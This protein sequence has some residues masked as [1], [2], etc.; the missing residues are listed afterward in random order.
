MQFRNPRS[1]MPA[2]VTLLVAGCGGG[3]GGGEGGS[4]EGGAPEAQGLAARNTAEGRWTGQTSSGFR[5]DAVILE[6]GQT[7]GLY[8]DG[9]S[10][11][12]AVQGSTATAGG[13]LSATLTEYSLLD[14]TAADA[15]FNGTVQEKSTID[16]TASTGTRLLL[17]YD[18]NYERAASNAELAGTYAIGA[19][20]QVTVDSSGQFTWAASA[21]CT[22]GGRLSPRPSGRNVFDASLTYSGAACPH[23]NGTSIS[24]VA[25]LDTASAPARLV[26]LALRPDRVIGFFAIGVRQ[27][28]PV[29]QGAG[30][31]APT[32][33]PAPVPLPAAPP[34]LTPPAPA[35]PAPPPAPPPQDPD[36]DDDDDDEDEDDDNNVQRVLGELERR[37]ESLLSGAVVGG[38]GN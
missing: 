27:A 38:T 28:D 2:V 22:L 5:V 14:D 36:D 15:V 20:G 3:G 1:L 9:D 30:A 16:A 13:N 7:W 25:Y 33:A 6:D 24:G 18:V 26:A 19:A 17:S 11:V 8:S 21:Q 37:L 34:A 32:P 31:P 35:A 29:A 12:G 10:P 4:G 23:A